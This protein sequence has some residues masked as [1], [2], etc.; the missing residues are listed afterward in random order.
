MEEIAV[1]SAEEAKLPLLDT[2][3]PFDVTKPLDDEIEGSLVVSDSSK[4]EY[5]LGNKIMLLTNKVSLREEGEESA[6]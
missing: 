3:H 6:L 1:S 4:K 2:A 5:H